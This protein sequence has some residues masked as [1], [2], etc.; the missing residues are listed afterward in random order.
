MASGTGF[1]RFQVDRA[2]VASVF[3]SG[4]MRSALM[5]VA[6]PIASSAS[7]EA[8]A[9]DLRTAPKD[10]DRAPFTAEAKTLSF[11]AVAV[12]NASSTRGGM[13]ENRDHVLDGFN[14]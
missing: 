12:V 2:G 7:A 4:A 6:A 13:A 8:R 3:R 10:D 14:H 1:G 11:T 9:M 5:S